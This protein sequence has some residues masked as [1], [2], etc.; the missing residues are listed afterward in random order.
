MH[1]LTSTTIDDALDAFD[2]PIE[3]KSKSAAPAAPADPLAALAGAIDRQTTAIS[4]ISVKSAAQSAAPARQRTPAEVRSRID[5][6]R[7]LRELRATAE[8]KARRPDA[9]DDAKERRINAG[10][11]QRRADDRDA[12]IRDLKSQVRELQKKAARP[13]GP[14]AAA[15]TPE[16]AKTAAFDLYRKGVQN[17]L[18]TGETT[19]AG[20]SLK[21]IQDAV[22][23]LDTKA[24]SASVGPDGGFFVQPEMDNGP[25]EKLLL[26]YSPIRGLATVRTISSAEFVKHANKRGLATRWVGAEQAT[27]EDATPTFAELRFPAMTI[28]SEPRIPQ[29]ALED[30]AIDL[31]ALIAEEGMEAIAEAEGAAFTTGDGD[32]KPRGYLAYD[33]IADASWVW[34]KVGYLATGAD[35]AFHSTTPGDVIKRT[36]L[37]LKRALRQN[38]VW[39]MNRSTIGSVRTMKDSTGAYLWSEGDM[40]KGIPAT[41]D[42]YVVEEDEQMPDIASGAHAIAFGDMKRA[43]LIVDRLGFQVFRNPYLAPPYVV[44]HMRKRVGGG[45]QNFEA[46][47]TIKF[48]S[49]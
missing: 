22:V 4:N 26:K 37:A 35:G 32:K 41:L 36:P 48:A 19:F 49:S 28:L 42:G 3:I 30:P 5:T 15:V 27:G 6:A 1:D 9:L 45:I 29:E 11:D 13:A 2:K 25:L 43:Y 17:Y 46:I 38:A 20:R 39:M 7:A 31:E 23:K 10:L 24:F 16:A 47:K 40:S 14:Q 21:S 12:E 34:G 44:F 8:R 18:R 33:T